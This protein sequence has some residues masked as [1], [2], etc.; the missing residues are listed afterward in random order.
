MGNDRVSMP[1]SSAGLTRFNEVSD[2]KWQLQPGHVFV[3]IALVIALVLL[4]HMY[5]NQWFGL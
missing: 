1:M 2:S 3:V 5:G 4:F